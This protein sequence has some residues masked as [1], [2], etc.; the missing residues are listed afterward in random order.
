VR[1]WKCKPVAD[2]ER[3]LNLLFFT[4]STSSKATDGITSMLAF[5]IRN[6]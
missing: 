6:F 4:R 1:S 3:D 5:L 2:E